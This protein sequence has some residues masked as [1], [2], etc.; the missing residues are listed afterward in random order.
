[1]TIYSHTNCIRRR[2]ALV[3]CWMGGLLLAAGCGERT[4]QSPVDQT[5]LVRVQQP[6]TKQVIDYE[7]FTGRTAAPYSLDLRAKVNGYLVRW[8]FD[9][10][11]DDAPVKDF[12]FVVG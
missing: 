12:N 6:E 10:K 2:I 3:A 5:P 4:D 9:K 8:N 11:S 7:Y 1:M